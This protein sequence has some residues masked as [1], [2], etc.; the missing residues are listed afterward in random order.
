VR[1]T[2]STPTRLAALAAA[3]GAAVLLAGCGGGSS[4]AAPA[5]GSVL[6]AITTTASS[7]AAPTTIVAPTTT[8]T[9][10]TPAPTSATPTTQA[11][12]GG[13]GCTAATLSL[14]L[15]QGSAG[16]GTAGE[17]LVF[18]NTGSTACTMTGF[19]G[20]SFVAGDQ[21]DQVG[22]AATRTGPEGGPVTLDPG[23]SASALV[24]VTQALNYPPQECQPTAVRGFRVYAPN[25]TAAMFV[26]APD[27]GCANGAVSLLRVQTMSTGTTGGI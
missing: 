9:S 24:L 19:P 14:S 5:T 12:A 4:S 20:V 11:A 26:A 7:S 27:T 10:S 21:G 22:A 3:S 15:G 25:D 13:G 16:A 2:S 8:T 6:P 23:G 18:T 17:P 1:R